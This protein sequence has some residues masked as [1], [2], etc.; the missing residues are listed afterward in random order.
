MDELA[1]VSRNNVNRYFQ[2]DTLYRY[3]YHLT[4][5]YVRE[6][7]ILRSL[8]GAGTEPGDHGVWSSIKLI[9]RFG[10]QWERIC[11][12]VVFSVWSTGDS[13][14]EGSLNRVFSENSLGVL[15]SVRTGI[16]LGLGFVQRAIIC[17]ASYSVLNCWIDV[18]FSISAAANGPV[19]A[20]KHS[21][22]TS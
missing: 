14:S 19:L 5:L 12:P 10:C 9:V 7:G 22:Q 1:P 3:R 17:D 8:S 13:T 11:T 6:A 21:R 16:G 20:W 18:Q 2:F 15:W 4:E